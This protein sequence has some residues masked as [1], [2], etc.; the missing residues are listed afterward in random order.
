M[1][2]EEIDIPALLDE[3]GSLWKALASSNNSTKCVH[4]RKDCQALQCTNGEPKEITNPGH[5][6]LRPGFCDYCI[7]G[8]A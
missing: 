8:E 5:A 1:S 2:A 4:A 7:G 3:H 6:P